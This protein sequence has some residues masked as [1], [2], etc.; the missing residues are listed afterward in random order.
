MGGSE[1]CGK[2]REAV[3][4]PLIRLLASCGCVC[5]RSQQLLSMSAQLKQLSS[6]FHV[7]V[8]VINQVTDFFAGADGNQGEALGIEQVKHS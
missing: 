5:C 1:Q 2:A 7:P 4:S 8:V 3:S 6:I